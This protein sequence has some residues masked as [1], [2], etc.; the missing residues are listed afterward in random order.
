[1]VNGNALY[2]YGQVLCFFYKRLS[3]CGLKIYDGCPRTQEI[4]LSC[5]TGRIMTL[6]GNWTQMQFS[7]LSF[8]TSNELVSDSQPLGRFRFQCSDCKT[9]AA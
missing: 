8:R 6:F 9:F 3:C 5:M 4:C 2:V 7:Q 1:M